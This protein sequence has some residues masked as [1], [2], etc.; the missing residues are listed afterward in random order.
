MSS[1]G[2]E[3]GSHRGAVRGVRV[4]LAV[5][6]MMVGACTS[7]VQLETPIP[8]RSVRTTPAGPTGRQVLD[9]LVLT[10]DVSEVPPA[11]TNVAT[12]PFGDA[13]DQLGLVTDVHRTPIPY[14]PRSF[15]IGPDGSI[16][17][18]DVVKHR[19]AHFGP[20]GSYLG[21]IGG[22][23][24]DRFSPRP[25]DVLF[26]NRKMYVLEELQLAATLVTIGA[27]RSLQRSQP[28]D[29]GRPVVLEMLYP[30]PTGVAARF[31]GWA[32]EIGAGPRGIARFDPPAST[33]ARFLP[34]VPLPAGYSIALEASSDQDVDLTFTDA[35][36]VTVRPVHLQLVVTADGRHKVIPMVAG[37]AIEAVG[38]D[39]VAIF[40]QISPAR[41]G[42]ADR[43]GGG[44]WLF[45][46]GTRGPVTWE[47]LPTPEISNEEQARHLAAGPDG[48]IYLMLPTKEGERIYSR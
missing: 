2:D 30:S 6:L 23:K 42:D 15:A 7:G 8:S 28:V 36:A 47:R 32:D 5:V 17:I 11:W 33:T 27:D 9:R 13:T 3:H 39:R 35:T 26:S 14:L 43:F 34:G 24:F 48:R 18:L 45:Q 10:A 22:F 4:A 16:W 25:R 29:Q 31:D 19:L 41:P 46:L 40:V 38:A 21:A 1:F 44:Q 12:I 20:T 37:E